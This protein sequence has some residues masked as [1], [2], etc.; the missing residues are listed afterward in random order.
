MDVK[1]QQSAL[2]QQMRMFGKQTIVENLK[3]LAK[4]KDNRYRFF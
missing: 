4:I 2:Q 1:A 3:K